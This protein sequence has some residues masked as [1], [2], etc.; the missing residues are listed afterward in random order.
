MMHWT[1]RANIENEEYDRKVAL[2]ALAGYRVVESGGCWYVVAPDP[3]YAGHPVFKRTTQR[4]AWVTAYD[5][6]QTSLV[7]NE[8]GWMP[9]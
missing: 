6:L 5:H 4:S 1:T 9:A 7:T 8:Q 3:R 2:A